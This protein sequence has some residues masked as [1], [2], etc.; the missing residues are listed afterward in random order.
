[1]ESCAELRTISSQ[2]RSSRRSGYVAGAWN[3]AAR[4]SARR[5]SS[6]SASAPWRFTSTRFDVTP[7]SMLA[8]EPERSSPSHVRESLGRRAREVAGERGDLEV[9]VVLQ[10]VGLGDHPAEPG[11]GH[12]V[13]RAVHAQQVTDR[14]SATSSTWSRSGGRGPWRRRAA[15]PR[16]RTRPA[17]TRH[18][19]TSRRGLPHEGVLGH[20]RGHAPPHDGVAEPGQAQ[21]L[22]H[23]RDVA[24]H[25]GQVADVHDA[26]ERRSPAEAHL[27]VAHDGLAR[28]QE[29]VHE[30]VPGP[31]AQPTGGGQ[32]PQPPLG[33]GPHLEV[34]VDDG[35]LPVQHE[36][37]D[38]WRRAR[39]GGSGCRPA[40]RGPGG[41]PGRTCTIP[42]PS[43]CEE[44]WQSGGRS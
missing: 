44:R 42:G 43:A 31:H 7:M 35:H 36:V 38:S 37:R 10:L 30:D 6:R 34:V 39:E 9:E 27:E 20:L 2:A 15:R 1:M 13:V 29:L 41:S 3:S 18:G 26:A 11:L 8:R 40:P 22:G 19:R 16:C 21:D 23:L 17:G 14:N 32:R 5:S 24:E 4:G 33:L 28:G 25:V 12:Q